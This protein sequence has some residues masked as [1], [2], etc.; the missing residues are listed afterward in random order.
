TAG[1]RTVTGRLVQEI[2]T[3]LPPALDA[4]AGPLGLTHTFP[5]PATVAAH[6]AASLAGAPYLPMPRGRVRA[7]LALS[8][9][10]STGAL[11]L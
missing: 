7:V 11:D 1:A 9:A 4:V 10:V 8:D 3:P 6:C 2:G 5:R